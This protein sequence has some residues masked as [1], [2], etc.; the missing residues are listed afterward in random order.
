MGNVPAG[1]PRAAAGGS[2]GGAA[3]GSG[4]LDVSTISERILVSGRLTRRPSDLLDHRVNEEDLARW[5]KRHNVEHVTLMN[6]SSKN[7]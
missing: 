4:A 5:L 3:A 6:L 2:G 7:R 1:P